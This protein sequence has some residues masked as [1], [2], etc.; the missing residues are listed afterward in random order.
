MDTNR[1]F[2]YKYHKV[3]L[4]NSK[5]NKGADMVNQVQDDARERELRDLFQ[6]EGTT[7]RIEP[8]GILNL[9]DQAIEFELKSTT[10]GTVSTVRDLG[11]DHIRKWENTHWIFGF[12]TTNQET[13]RL[14]LEYCL[15]AS[16]AKMAPWIEHMEEYIKADFGLAALVP[17]LVTLDVMDELIGHKEAYSLEDAKSIQ[18]RQYN[19]D[20]YMELMDLEDGYSRG[21][22]L[23]I[24]RD[25]C[26]YL[27]RRG[28]T[29]NNPHIPKGF[30]EENFTED[31]MITE[32]HAIRLRELVREALQD[33]D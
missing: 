7:G 3:Y 30:F 9:D 17:E 23:E 27:I 14:K 20:K 31:E 13:G 24:L 26:K 4:W 19:K 18:K 6:L 16:P 2:L 5:N 15:Y 12:Y 11:P 22:I 8:D 32:N 28:S 1:Y 33:N 29:L 10:V 25:R 21:I